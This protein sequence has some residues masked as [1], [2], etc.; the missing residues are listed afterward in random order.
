MGKKL[1]GKVE[2]ITEKLPLLRDPHCEFVLLRSCLALPKV[3]FLLRA[4]DTSN[5]EDLL[6]TFDSITRE[7]LSKILGSTVSD[8]QWLQARLPVAMGGLGLRCAEDH[9]PT[10]FASS[11]L[12]S[13]TLVRKLL[14]KDDNGDAPNLPQPVLERISAKQGEVASTEALVGVSQKSASLKVDLFNQSLLL[15]HI[16][17]EGEVREMA[18]LQSLGLPHAGDWL[19]VV[20]QPAL[21]LHLRAPEFVTSLKYRLGIPIYSAEGPCPSC[22]APSDQMGDHALGCA[23]HGDRI[24]RHDQLRDVIFEA[25]ASA[26]LAPARE[27]RHL[28]PGSAARPGDVVIKRWSDG[29]DGALDITV[30]GSLARSN[31]EAAAEVAGSAL[32]KAV[33]RKVQGVAEACQQQGL[34]FLPIAVETLGG[35]HQV[36][37]EQV[38]R[39]G[40]ALARNQGSDEKVATRQLFQRLSLTL[41]RGNAALIIGRRPDDD[42]ASAEIDGVM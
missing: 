31:V 18:R 40:A 34:V 39:I 19:S 6:N 11:L 10:A 9:A 35:L 37:V 17:E 15:N 2:K 26:S 4:L 42:F 14:G 23:K 22:S 24:A 41:M 12:S 1:E 29:K 27:E 5:H 13:Q 36:A 20:P 38:K 7:A 32:A 25:A 30:T 3:M 33:Q 21:G 16:T 8:A 28:L